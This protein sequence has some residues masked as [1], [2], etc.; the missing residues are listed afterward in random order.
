MLGLSA[1]LFFSAGL[2][3]AALLE[4]AAGQGTYSAEVVGITSAFYV[5]SGGASGPSFECT[6]GAHRE[7]FKISHSFGVGGGGEVWQ[8][9][10]LVVT[11]RGEAESKA[12]AQ[13]AM[14]IQ[15]SET[16]MPFEQQPSSIYIGALPQGVH[17]PMH[18]EVH[19]RKACPPQVCLMP[20]PEVA[21]WLS[22]A[23]ASPDGRGHSG[24]LP[25]DAAGSHWQSTSSGEVASSFDE[26]V[27][28][29]EPHCGW[30]P[31]LSAITFKSERGNNS[32]LEV[33][34]SH[35]LAQNIS[36]F[37]VWA[38]P[39]AL[40]EAG[41]WQTRTLSLTSLSLRQEELGAETMI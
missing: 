11:L 16:K 1:W 20:Q 3:L 6:V 5:R 39:L 34:V 13:V 38:V 28:V 37:K 22:D 36:V 14:R 12:A 23:A 27:M 4:R 7:P 30:A 2:A 17:S 29:A 21:L 8:H 41:M 35:W 19:G 33:D 18:W 40:G 26:V 31:P 10:G 15:L 24:T 32:A 25:S 9:A